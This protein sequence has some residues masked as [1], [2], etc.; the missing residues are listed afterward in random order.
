MA[1]D[2][3]NLPGILLNLMIAIICAGQFRE[4]IHFIGP[5]PIPE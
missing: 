5:R 4:D 3:S 2:T 1:H